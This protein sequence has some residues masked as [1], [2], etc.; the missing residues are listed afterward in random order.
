[1]KN[2]TKETF[3]LLWDKNLYELLRRKENYS[4]YI[5]WTFKEHIDNLQN[6]IIELSEWIQ[7]WDIK[8][9]Q[10]EFMDVI[11]MIWQL[12]NKLNK[13]WFLKWLDFKNQKEKILSRSPNLKTC[14]KV[15]REV[16]NILWHKNKENETIKR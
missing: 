6:E 4:E 1:M 3:N 10:E 15:S 2:N 7:K 11:F 5:N 12:S 14:N 13:E 16:E 8:N 9:I